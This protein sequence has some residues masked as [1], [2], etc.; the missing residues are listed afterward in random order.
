MKVLFNIFGIPVHFFGVMIALG[1]L[2]GLAVAYFE[3]KRKNLN[4]DKMLDI[5]IYSIISAIVTA[6][7]FYVIFYDLSYYIS[8]PL[9]IFKVYEGGLSIHG[10]LIG[11]FAFSFCGESVK[12]SNM[13]D[14][15]LLGI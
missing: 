12:V 15:Y 8:K 14:N 11:P 10:G 5:V 3:V 2:G 13:M 1:I 7:L 6:R 4:V 9:D